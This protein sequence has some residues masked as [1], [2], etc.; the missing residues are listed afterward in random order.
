ML[1]RVGV[2]R[3][4][5]AMAFLRRLNASI[6]RS[7]TW[8]SLGPYSLVKSSIKGRGNSSEVGNEPPIYTAKAD[9]G[10]KLRL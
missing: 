7:S 6:F 4:P 3:A 9:E 10:A 1:A 5:E 8:G 2:D